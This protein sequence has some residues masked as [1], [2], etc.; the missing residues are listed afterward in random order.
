VD[1]ARQYKAESKYV[2]QCPFGM[3]IQERSYTATVEGY[4]F[5]FNGQEGDDEV[6]G[7]GNSYTAEFWQYDSRLGR[8]FNRDPKS[9]PSISVYACFANNP[10]IFTDPHGD[11]IAQRN[12]S[13]KTLLVLPRCYET[14][15][16]LKTVYESGMKAGFNIAIIEDLDEL[17]S[18]AK[19]NGLNYNHVIVG[20]HGIMTESVVRI[21][22]GYENEYREADLDNVAEKLNELGDY[23]NTSNKENGGTSLVLLQCLGAAPKTVDEEG[24]VVLFSDP[25]LEKLSKYTSDN[26]VANAGLTRASSDMFLGDGK[27]LSF[28]KISGATKKYN[29]YYTSQYKKWRLFRPNG[30]NKNVGDIRINSEGTVKKNK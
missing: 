29:K 23:I 1:V 12:S 3:L 14:N 21:G 18:D 5:G 30:E 7:S 20:Q 24:N 15:S 16:T 11:T 19:S 6:S 8:R 27:S 28:E 9:N 17:L 13:N 26:V 2:K 25:L 10:V 22:R 4:R